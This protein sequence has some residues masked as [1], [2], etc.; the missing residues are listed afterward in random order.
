MIIQLAPEAPVLL[1]AAAGLAL[2]AHISGAVTGMAAGAVSLF[3]RK[4][5][6]LHRV[7]GTVFFAAML[8]M[9]GA[10]AVTAPFLPDRFSALM[11]VFVVYLA[12]TGWVAVQRGPG[13][14]GRFERWAM[15]VPLLVAA[16]DF[17]FAWAGQS[18]PNGELDGE[19]AILGWIVGAIALAAALAD[20]SVL[21][22]GGVAGAQRVARHLWR[23]TFALFIAWGSFAG[24]PKA[25]PPVL[26]GTNLAIVPAL[27]V[28]AMMFGWLAWTLR[29]RRR[30]APRS[31][32][33]AA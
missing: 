20:R 16:G 28:L 27:V 31:G 23:M 13:Q 1:R 2:V 7:T 21:R 17:A 6:R 15:A 25:I 33:A 19:P 14:V 11:G 32:A 29:P 10:A 30:A 24:Q 18:M 22:R 9:G 12:S 3:A 5:G 8:A 26:K 4:G